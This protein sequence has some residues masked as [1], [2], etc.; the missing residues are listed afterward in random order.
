MSSANARLSSSSTMALPPYFT[1]TILPWNALSHGSASTS[2][3]RLL[4]LRFQC[5]GTSVT[6]RSRCRS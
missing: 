4:C 6:V 3:R 5:A 2:D 1:T